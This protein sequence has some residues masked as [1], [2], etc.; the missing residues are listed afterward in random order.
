MSETIITIV[1]YVEQMHWLVRDILLALSV[2]IEYI[3][4][5]FPGDTVVIAA[6]IFH[7]QGALSFLEIYCSI[8]L[9]TC[10]GILFDYLIGRAIT[11]NKLPKKL[12]QKIINQQA[13][14]TIVK[15][16]KKWGC[17]LLIVN[18][19]LPGIRA[20]FF[21]A[22][23]MTRMPL[24]AVLWAGGISALLFNS[25][26]LALGYLAGYNLERIDVLWKNYNTLVYGIMVTIFIIFIGYLFLKKKS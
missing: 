23:G 4:P 19:F 11:N 25:G 13:L 18:R 24:N 8:M 12:T 15:W 9:G 3:F 16:Y 5:I 21:I 14:E 26:L 20:F 7:A 22:A 6:G 1:D 10:I 2:I 17:L